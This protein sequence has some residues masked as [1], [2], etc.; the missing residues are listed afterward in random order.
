MRLMMSPRSPSARNVASASSRHHPLA[1]T[2]LMGE[3]EGS[4]L[5]E[6]ADLLGQVF[7]GLPI[8]TRREIDDALLT[9][10]AD[11]LP[12][13]PRPA[14]GLDLVVQAAADVEVGARPKLLRNEILRPRPHA[15][16][17]I[18]TRDHEVLPVIGAAAQD[19]V[20][21]RVVGV[22]VI[23]ADPVEL[24]SEVLLDLAA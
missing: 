24:G 6:P 11:K 22:P 4:E 10:I 8:R 1:R 17:D 3:A 14:L 16:A 12:V 5:A 13:E 19:D 21:V 15:L 2:G 9:G 23:D 18:V 7:V 20:D